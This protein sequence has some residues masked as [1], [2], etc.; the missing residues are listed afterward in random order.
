MTPSLRRPVAVPL[1]ELVGASVIAAFAFVVTRVGATGEREVWSALVM[2][3]IIVLLTLPLLVRAGRGD[4]DPRILRL[5]LMALVLKAFA[6]VARYYMAFGLYGGTADAGVYHNEGARLSESYRHLDFTADIGHMF[7]G[8]G[9]M[10][11]AT[12][13]LYAVTGPSIF[14]A[15]AVFS[16]LG[17]WGLWFLYR[18]FRIAVPD[19]DHHRYAL[20]VL[21][22]PSMLFWPSGLGKEAWMTFGIGLVALGAAKLLSRD[23]QWPVPLVLGLAATMVVRPHISAAL[24]VGLAA[25][26]VLRRPVGVRTALTP[27]VRIASVAAVLA[28]GMLVVRYAAG[29]LDIGDLSIST[30]DKT[31]RGTQE[32]TAIGGSSFEAHPV[33]S[34]IDLPMAAV[35]VLIRPF[36]FEARNVQS[37][38]AALEGTVLLVLLARA[39]PQTRAVL[40]EL[41]TQPYLIMC[42]VYTLLFV[43]AFSSFSNFGILTRE[44][45][46]VLPFVV[47]FLAVAAGVRARP[48][49]VG[50]HRSTPSSTVTHTLQETR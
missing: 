20:L 30:L 33:N 36:L 28:V 9:F 13:V 48:R 37:G 4:P 32:A 12:G 38:I 2:I 16:L 14:V 15:Y 7:I 1:T 21:F 5:L 6:T 47:A 35:S 11:A 45:V 43:Y 24:F 40:R 3:P 26:V 10:R 50:T 19:G 25:A 44:R 8:T 46:Q 22:L 17:F 34:P 42:A 18:A 29:F 27:L 31:M 39:L 41:R 23:H 49:P